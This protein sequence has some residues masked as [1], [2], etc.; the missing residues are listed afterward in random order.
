LGAN[1][2]DDQDPRLSD[3]EY[4]GMFDRLGRTRS[5]E[6]KVTRAT[7]YSIPVLSKSQ[8]SSQ[9]VSFLQLDSPTIDGIKSD[10][11]RRMKKTIFNES[12]LPS[13]QN[14]VDWAKSSLDNAAAVHINNSMISF[15]FIF[16]L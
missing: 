1:I 15:I 2:P 4:E 16:S 5:V 7:P 12:L 11:L 6:Q 14:V 10:A 3:P 8:R 9:Q 13:T